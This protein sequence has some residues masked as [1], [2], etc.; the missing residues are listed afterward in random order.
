MNIWLKEA[1]KNNSG[2]FQPHKENQFRYKGENYLKEISYCGS[3]R[4]GSNLIRLP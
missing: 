2:K 1:D 4:H 3:Q